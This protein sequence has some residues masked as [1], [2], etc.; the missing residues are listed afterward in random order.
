MKALANPAATSDERLSIW[1]PHPIELAIFALL[2]ALAHF[3][4]R[5]AWGEALWSAAIAFSLLP[6]GEIVDCNG[7]WRWSWIVLRWLCAG[8]VLLVVIAAFWLH[9]SGDS[10]WIT[11]AQVAAVLLGARILAALADCGI[12]KFPPGERARK[13]I[14]W[15]CGLFAL[16]LVAQL[17]WTIDWREVALWRPNFE[18]IRSYRPDWRGATWILWMGMVTVLFVGPPLELW[19]R[20]LKPF[21]KR[22]DLTAFQRAGA[23]LAYLVACC[24]WWAVLVVAI[25][26]IFSQPNLLR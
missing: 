24:L 25:G 1:S 20:A 14:N 21:D 2:A 10:F 6:R 7:D 18:A 12:Y 8:E 3:V 19:N 4:W 11:A 23:A 9:Q 15:V 16:A 5:E 26:F 13:I 17:L 22:A